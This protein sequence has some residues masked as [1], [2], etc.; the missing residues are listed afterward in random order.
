M[1][2]HMKHKFSLLLHWWFHLMCTLKQSLLL[3]LQLDNQLLSKLM[4]MNVMLRV[5]CWRASAIWLWLATRALSALIWLNTCS[6]PVAFDCWHC[7]EP[8]RS[9]RSRAMYVAWSIRFAK[10]LKL[11]MDNWP[12]SCKSRRI[13]PIVSGA[14]VPVST[15][16]LLP[17]RSVSISTVCLAILS[18]CASSNWHFPSDCN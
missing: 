11:S 9:V 5:T 17:I 6:T 13:M 4:Q 10:S 14:C 2:V 7:P 12:S 16:S 15:P 3:V 8:T 18:G 1:L